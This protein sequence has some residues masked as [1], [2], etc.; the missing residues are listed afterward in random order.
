MSKVTSA[1]GR[2]IQG[3]SQQPNNIKRDGQCSLLENMQPSVVEGLKV[4][5]GTT[6]VAQ[7]LS[8]LPDNSK[9]HH[10]RR[11]DDEEYF[12]VIRP[13][14][15]PVVFNSKGVQQIVIDESS[16]NSYILNNNP[17]D[18][19]ET[20]TISDFTFIVNKSV[21]VLQGTATSAALVNEALIYV[22][23]TNYGKY[24]QVIVNGTVAGQYQAP[25]GELPE[26][27]YDIDTTKVARELILGGSTANFTGTFTLQADGLGFSAL[28]PLGATN[29]S[30][31]PLSTPTATGTDITGQYAVFYYEQTLVGGEP[32][33]YDG[34]KLS[35]NYNIIAN[36][37]GSLGGF[38]VNQNGNVIHIKR[39]DGAD[40]TLETIDGADGND[41]IAI[42]EF[43]TDI[44]KLPPYAPNGFM[45]KIQQSGRKDAEGYWL[46]AIDRGGNVVKWAEVIS[47]STKLGLNKNT[48]PYTLIRDSLIAGVATFKIKEGAWEER[49]VGDDD[50]NP[51]PPFADANS[52]S[53]ISTLGIFQNRLYLTSGESVTFSRSSEFFNFFRTTTQT[54]VDSDPASGY[55]DS[56][57]INSL[58]NSVTLDGDLILFSRNGQF[59][60][61]G[62]QPL[63]L[64]NLTISNTNSFESQPQAKPVAS[65]EAIFFAFANGQFT[66]IREYYTDSETDTKRARPVTEHVDRY[67]LGNVS[68]ME[69]SPNTNWLVVKC[70]T[71]NE[72]YLYNWLW[73]G[74]EK[75]QS[76]WHKWV[77][78]SDSDVISCAF[79]VDKLYLTIK[80]SGGYYLEYIELNDTTDNVLGFEVRADRKQLLTAT[81]VGDVYTMI[82]PYPSEDI[83]SLF[84]IRSTGNYSEEIGLNATFE[85]SGGILV[86]SEDL[87]DTT[88]SILVGRKF[89]SRYVLP[90]PVIRDFKDKLIGIDKLM[91][92]RL[93]VNYES[94]GEIRVR[95]KN[96]T[97]YDRTFKLTGR[98]L[99]SPNNII[100]FAPTSSGQ[101]I[102][103]VMQKADQTTV[104]LITEDY[105]PFEIRDIEWSGQFKQRGRRV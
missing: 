48:M 67:L 22:Q 78:P 23:F 64:E 71:P 90:E 99:G 62:Q 7:L 88:V 32:Y 1:F 8:S 84:F 75:V 35:I 9:V 47:P 15:L 95:I 49:D 93:Y 14:A 5:A 34:Q 70:A 44:G 3:V 66:G 97:G 77:F 24:Y 103:P 65:G 16:N 57:Q 46:K 56:S 80:R 11:G 87:G 19:F 33:Y 25:N 73:L 2:P 40:F 53:T 27:V 81:K 98:I 69:T 89:L 29:G 36:G 85:R 102:I 26:H 94:S 86:C 38:E 59:K 63:T 83:D 10:Y 28:L 100:G 52:T 55:A 17:K 42:K 4:R 51:F 104:E 45:V 68:F 39:T 105:V 13:N 31:P 92:S 82:D 12:I 6:H 72:L 58:V 54:L 76:A 79:S 43:I 60:V 61:S 74:N 101:H 50:S 30:N 21:K 37:L 41:L 20:V 91:L 96:K 18:S